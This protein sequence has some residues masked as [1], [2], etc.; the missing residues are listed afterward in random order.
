[1]I[2]DVADYGI[3]CAD[4]NRSVV[5]NSDVMFAAALC[6][7]ANVAARLPRDRVIQFSECGD[8]IVARN[9]SR[10]SHRAISSS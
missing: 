9:V 3:E 6:G 5:G 8:K 7:K 1:M 2:G 10:Q 4:A